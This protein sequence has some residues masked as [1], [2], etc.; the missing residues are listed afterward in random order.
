LEDNPYVHIFWSLGNI[1]NLDEYRIELKTDIGV[2][3][4]RY[5]TPTVSQVVAI[6]EEG[7]DTAK[8]FERS[9]MVCGTSR[10]PQYIKAYHGCYDPILYPLFFPH[11]EVGW[12]KKILYADQGNPVE[13]LCVSL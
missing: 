2:D 8:Q 1:E 9:I 6:W 5:N 10:E 13:G 7:S 11:G 3:Q 12:N 4:R